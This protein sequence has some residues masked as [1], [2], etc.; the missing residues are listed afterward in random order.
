MDN[1]IFTSAL[2]ELNT[3]TEEG[4]FGEES[5]ALLENQQ[6]NTMPQTHYQTLL[7]IFN[8]VENQQILVDYTNVFIRLFSKCLKNR[9]ND[10]AKLISTSIKGSIDYPMGESLSEYTR[11]LETKKIY[12]N[13]LAE[14][15]SRGRGRFTS[16]D[17]V[18]IANNA[19]NTY[20]DGFEYVMKLFTYVIAILKNSNG[21][22]YDLAKISYMTSRQKLDHFNDQDKLKQFSL[23][24]SGWNDV[25]RNA[26]SHV[27]IR[28]DFKTG[29]FI[30]KNEH[31]IKV[32]G[33]KK[34]VPIKNPIK[35]TVE[36]FIGK[37]LPRVGYFIQ[38]YIAAALLVLL[39]VEDESLF[40]KAEAH[41]YK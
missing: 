37:D 27:D 2:D 28:Y 18:K 21:E 8:D 30:G 16:A 22:D 4:F 11:Y 13:S 7:S 35:I 3:L 36:E 23:L 20:S 40:N 10:L 39:D 31:R 14:V 6:T 12:T 41:I 33:S 26:T 1:E 34:T 32:K 5:K 24:S 19:L 9:D 15:S 29:M 38:G 17:K 25:L